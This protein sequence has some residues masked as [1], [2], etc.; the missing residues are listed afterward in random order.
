MTTQHIKI[1]GIVLLAIM[2]LVL[3]IQNTE[4]VE[5]RLLVTTVTLPRA[6]ILAAMGAIG[7]LLGMLVTLRLTADRKN[8]D[9]P[10][11]PSPAPADES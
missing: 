7:F 4:P 3:V 9:P 5:T 1:A 10:T 6:V 8:D 2:L 11:E